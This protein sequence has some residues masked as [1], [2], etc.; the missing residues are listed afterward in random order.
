MLPPMHALLDLSYANALRMLTGQHFAV[1]LGSLH[2]FLLLSY[3]DE[4]LTAREQ[5]GR[6][7]RALPCAGCAIPTPK[8][9][10]VTRRLSA[11]SAGRHHLP[12]DPCHREQP[13]RHA[14]LPA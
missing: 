14:G 8:R 4:R 2:S 6:G 13:L 1:S 11:S 10:H 7:S 5:M 3:F 12:D 9:D